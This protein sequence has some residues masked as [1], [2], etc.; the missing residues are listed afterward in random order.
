MLTNGVSLLAVRSFLRRLVR[1]LLGDIGTRSSQP[2]D[3]TCLALVVGGTILALPA[4][5]MPRPTI[6][7]LL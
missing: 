1:G 2:T 3:R 5:M 6:V 4:A 7:A